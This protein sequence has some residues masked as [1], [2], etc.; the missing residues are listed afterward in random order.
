M[1][2]GQRLLAICQSGVWLP[3]ANRQCNDIGCA[4]KLADGTV[5][6]WGAGSC[7]IGVTQAL[8][9]YPYAFPVGVWVTEISL[10]AKLGSADAPVVGADAASTSTYAVTCA[11]TSGTST[12]QTL[13]FRFLAIG[14]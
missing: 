8:Y 1:L 9:P 10:G 3:P 14:V 11:T 12:G 6:Q 7:V 4:E 5:I 13:G 2:A